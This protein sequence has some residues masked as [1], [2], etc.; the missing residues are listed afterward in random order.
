VLA[1][2]PELVDRDAMAK[3]PYLPVSL[4][5]VIAAGLK[6]FRDMGLAEAYCGAP[7]E[8]TMEEGEATYETLV[9]MTIEL[10]RALVAGTGGRDRSGLFGRV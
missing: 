8:A 4:P 1:Q 9:E 10:I 6:D 2:A 7:A 3:L 5:E